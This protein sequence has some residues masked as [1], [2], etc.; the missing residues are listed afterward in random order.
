VKAHPPPL[1]HQ[2][3]ALATQLFQFPPV[4]GVFH[5]HPHQ[6]LHL[7]KSKPP[8]DL[9]HGQPE[10]N[11]A[12]APH[13]PAHPH[14]LHQAHLM[15]SFKPDQSTGP[16]LL[17]AHPAHPAHHPAQVKNSLPSQAAQAAPNQKT[18]L[19]EDPTTAIPKSQNGQLTTT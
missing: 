2:A 12:Q 8:Q 7:M 15:K 1:H 11:Q 14:L 13:H 18:I 16:S 17:Q 9:L 5:H 19:M 3:L 10:L 4:N 6:A